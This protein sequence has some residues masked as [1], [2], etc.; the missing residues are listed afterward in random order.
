MRDRIVAGNWKL[1]GD[2]Q[3]ARGLLDAIAGDRPPGVRVAVFPPMPYLGELTDHYGDSGL[4]FGA[5]D[6]DANEQGAYTGEVSPRMLLD[7][8][9]RY[10][11]VGHSERRHFHEET[12][13]RVAHKFHAARKAG[14]VPVLCIGE[15]LHQ[16]EAGQ[17]EWAI[18]RQLGPVLSSGGGIKCFDGAVIAYEPVWAIGTGRTASPAQA[19]QV[20]AFIRGELGALDAKIAGSLPI[21]Y[22][23]SVKPD[24]AAELFAQPDV[25]GGL[26]GGASLVARDFLAIARAAAR[27]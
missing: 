16:R 22:G 14:L 6:V 23:G 5:Q 4:E 1:H 24:N 11:L 17:T 21:L 8:G 26:I 10:A 7:V 3:F 18:E 9:C 12:S 2:R 15:T 13:E 25:D 20:H 27:P 19:Q